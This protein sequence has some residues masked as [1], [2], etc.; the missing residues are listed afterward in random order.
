MAQGTVRLLFSLVGQDKLSSAI[1]T[2]QKSL[3]SFADSAEKSGGRAG[4]VFGKLTGIIGMEMPGKITD[5]KS[6]FDLLG[7][8]VDKIAAAINEV[9]EGEKRLN[10]QR[11]FEQA[12]G[13]ARASAEAMDEFGEAVGNAIDS[14]QIVDFANQMRFAGLETKT[15]SDTLRTAFI[16]AQGTNQDMLSVADRLKESLV[17]GSQGGFEMLGI[18]KNLNAE[19]EKQARAMGTNVDAMS[20]SEKAQLRLQV[21]NA[22]MEK[23]F[24][25]MNIDVKE[26]STTFQGFKSSVDDA[27]GAA[28]EFA[29]QQFGETQREKEAEALKKTVMELGNAYED[30]IGKGATDQFSKELSKATGVAEEEV[31]GLVFAFR[32]ANKGIVTEFSLEKLASDLQQQVETAD[33]ARLAQL[34]KAN[35]EEARESRRARQDK[36]TQIEFFNDQFRLANE[37]LAKSIEGSSDTQATVIEARINE[38]RFEMGLLGAELKPLS[39][40]VQRALFDAKSFKKSADEQ[41]KSRAESNKKESARAKSKEAEAKARSTRLEGLRQRNLRAEIET[42][43]ITD[44]RRVEELKKQK[45][46][47]QAAVIEIEIA[48]RSQRLTKKQQRK[49]TDNEVILRETQLQESIRQIREDFASLQRDDAKKKHDQDLADLEKEA[50]DAEDHANR[51]HDIR[52]ERHEK[53]LQVAEE[54]ASRAQSLSGDLRRYDQ[55]TATIIQGQAEVT[56][57]LAQNS[58]NAAK[59]ASAAIAAGGRTTESLIKNDR[60]AAATRAAFETASGFASIAAADPVG[61][62]MH[63]TAAGLFAALAG[64]SGGKKGGARKQ[65]QSI[66]RG[67]G[68]GNVGFGGSQTGSNVTVNVAGFVSGTSKDLGVELG[69]TIQGVQDTGLGTE[70]V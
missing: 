48:E 24:V 3:D 25:S 15:I 57:A 59:Q 43:N 35:Q 22:E 29:A 7:G 65:S 42:Q 50:Q 63:F 33:E 54:F 19:I 41:M 32:K 37:E 4:K 13:G 36:A 14:Q 8:A 58:G 66:S 44:K 38:I 69:N 10:A 23:K 21:V 5:L 47:D 68:G 18:T 17:T 20:T 1:T 34:K 46:F 16:V 67:G 49:L 64:K 31:Q 52:R 60:A 40:E 28:A 62:T 53:D 9:A 51:I 55:D 39:S 27:T 2:S 70:T 26:L 6:G 11:I 61:A 12:S 45:K 30:A 56:Q